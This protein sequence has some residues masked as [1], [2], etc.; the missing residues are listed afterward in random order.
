[1]HDAPKC[2]HCIMHIGPAQ[3]STN[4]CI[5]HVHIFMRLQVRC[6]RACRVTSKKC[7]PIADG[8]DQRTH[9]VILCNFCCLH[10]MGLPRCATSHNSTEV[11]WSQR[12][13]VESVNVSVIC[14][15]MLRFQCMTMAKLEHRCHMQI[16]TRQGVLGAN[17]YQCCHASY[18]NT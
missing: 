7:H 3:D 11:C 2:N 17:R 18:T 1:M 15:S 4:N 14:P 16:L 6:C 5:L 12:P 8:S 13:R 9:T 10:P